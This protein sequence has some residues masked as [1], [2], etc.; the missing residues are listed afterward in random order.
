MKPVLGRGIDQKYTLIHICLFICFTTQFPVKDGFLTYKE[1]ISS[2]TSERNQH[3]N[4][5][6]GDESLFLEH[7]E[8]DISGPYFIDRDRSLAVEFAVPL[9]FSQL[10]LVSGLIPSNRNPF[11]ILGVFSLKVWLVLIFTTLLVSGAATLIYRVLPAKEKRKV[12]ETFSRYFWGYQSSLV[13][14]EF[15]GIDRWFLRH[16]WPS[17]SFRLLQSIWFTGGT[18]VLMYTY[19]GAII[20]AFTA[21]KLKPKISTIDELLADT[22]VQ[23]STFKNSYPMAFFSRLTNTKYE[24]LWLRLKNNLVTPPDKGVVPTWLDL[25]EDGKTI[26]IAD[27]LWMQNLIGERFMKTGKC[28]VRTIN[29]DLGAAYIAF[30]FRKELKNERVFK[31]F[32]KG[33]RRFNEGNL[34]KHRY[35]TSTLYYDICTGASIP[36]TDPLNLTDLAGAFILLGVGIG[37]AII[38]FAV[39]FSMN[40]KKNNKRSRKR[41]LLA[42]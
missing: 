33:L 28:N 12:P 8:T 36:I 4:G 26:F 1:S 40:L 5:F 3:G 13:G 21:D 31:N 25:V 15:G 2:N 10:T 32:N 22:K 30:A 11:L 41:T 37:L 39:E 16:V 14:K 19:Q 18:L 23:F 29:I 34:A 20:S 17:T 38:F 35:I 9:T 27:T 7:P 42:K 6:H 24:P